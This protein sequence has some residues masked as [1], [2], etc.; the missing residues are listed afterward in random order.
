M[1]SQRTVGTQLDDLGLAIEL[2]EGDR[3]IEATVT[4]VTGNGNVSEQHR[5]VKLPAD[6]PGSIPVPHPVERRIVTVVAEGQNVSEEQRSRICVWLEANGI[7]PRRVAQGAITIECTMR[8]DQVGRQIIG[9]CEY[10]ESADGHRELDWKT[11]QGAL[12]YERWV[13]Q[14]VPLDPDPA[15]KGWPARHAEI[16]AMKASRE[17]GATDE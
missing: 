16:A 7:D 6:P 3:V 13:V 17:S 11:R 14:E 8:G 15:W 4:L 2:E 5:P 1:T 10:Y 12:T 9:F